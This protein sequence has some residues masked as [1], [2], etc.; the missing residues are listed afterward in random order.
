MRDF[1]THIFVSFDDKA[2][3][4]AHLAGS[5]VRLCVGQAEPMPTARWRRATTQ[6]SHIEPK[7]SCSRAC[8]AALMRGRPL[9]WR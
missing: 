8:E 1:V 2:G 5:R 4:V 6:S 7:D 3:T 9:S